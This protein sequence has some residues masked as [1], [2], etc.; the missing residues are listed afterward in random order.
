M[1]IALYLRMCQRY[2]WPVNI[3][4]TTYCNTT[5]NYMSCDFSEQWVAICCIH[6]LALNWCQRFSVISYAV[7]VSNS[8]G[9]GWC[10]GNDIVTPITYIPSL[11]TSINYLSRCHL[12]RFYPHHGD[13]WMLG[14]KVVHWLTRCQK[15]RWHVAVLVVALTIWQLSLGMATTI[16]RE[17]C[18][19][20]SDIYT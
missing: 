12:V 11:T 1:P 18:Q 3:S 16:P 4:T 20:V 13:I 15:Y 19:I 17:S 2:N 9:C 6:Q 10:I 14:V 8:K 5:C 7:L